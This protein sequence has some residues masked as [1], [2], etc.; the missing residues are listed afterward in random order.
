MRTS[1]RW[2]SWVSLNWT[3]V[4][5]P[6]SRKQ[7]SSRTMPSSG[8]RGRSVGAAGAG[9]ADAVPIM[10]AAARLPA[11]YR[12]T[13]RREWA[14]R[15][16]EDAGDEEEVTGHRFV[17]GDRCTDPGKLLRRTA[18]PPHGERTGSPP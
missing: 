2:P 5:V 6:S 3:T 16:E 10:P 4:K 13:D 14:E 12:R 18:A 9:A 8:R 15:D 11:E 1:V 7:S 17:R